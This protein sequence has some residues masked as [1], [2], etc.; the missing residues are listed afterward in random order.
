MVEARASHR[1][2]K[3]TLTFTPDEAYR[4]ECEAILRAQKRNNDWDMVSPSDRKRY[5]LAAAGRRLTLALK[6]ARVAGMAFR[7]IAVPE[8]HKSGVV[9]YHLVI[10]EVGKPLLKHCQHCRKECS[11]MVCFGTATRQC[12]SRKRPCCLTAAW[13]YGFSQFKLVPSGKLDNAVHYATKYAAKDA[14]ARIRA[15][16]R[17]GVDGG[18]CSKPQDEHVRTYRRWLR[19]GLATI[20]DTGTE[21]KFQSQPDLKGWDLLKGSALQSSSSRGVQGGR[22]VHPPGRR[23]VGGTPLGPVRSLLREVQEAQLL[24]AHLEEVWG[25]ALT[26]LARGPPE[27]PRQQ[28]FEA[29]AA[30]VPDG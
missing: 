10:H 8:F 29:S 18:L 22:I 2:W 4:Y 3:A 7:Y 25:S 19:W 5:L 1:V 13:P 15:S 26:D 30:E 14:S 21:Q 11:C 20:V 9:H 23:P 6:R 17:Y 16:I 24:R 27:R 28:A 12:D